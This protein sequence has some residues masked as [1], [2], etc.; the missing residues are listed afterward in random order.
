MESEAEKYLARR[1]RMQNTATTGRI[2]RS[3]R[4]LAVQGQSMSKAFTAYAPN[5]LKVQHNPEKEEFSICMGEDCAVLQYKRTNETLDLF[6]TE[7]PVVF[8][9]QGVAALLAKVD[10]FEYVRQ[11]NLKMKLS[12]EYLQKYYRDNE[13]PELKKILA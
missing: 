13:T 5:D 6:H 11:N 3:A 2:L 8:R 4:S 12:C 1:G 9:G 10:A 7:V